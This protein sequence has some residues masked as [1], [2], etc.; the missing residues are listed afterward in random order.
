MAGRPK[1]EKS[2]KAALDK[3]I[4]QDPKALR[5]AADKLLLLAS[6][7]EAWAIKELA[8]RLDGKPAQTLVGDKDQPITVVIKR[9]APG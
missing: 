4:A 5:R 2:F 8:D 9:F 6:D 3:A 7:G 1:A